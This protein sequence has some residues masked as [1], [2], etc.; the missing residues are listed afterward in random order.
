MCDRS[1]LDN[2]AYLVHQVGRRPDLD[3]LVRSWMDSYQ[4]LFKVPILTP[5]SFD[6]TRDTSATFQKD[7]DGVIDTLVADFQ[8]PCVHLDPGDRD[9]WVDVIMAQ[10]GLPRVPPQ[11]DIFGG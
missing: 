4:G 5:P 9:G 11:M 6:G 2:Y 1:A 10:V 3:A 8:V 7:I